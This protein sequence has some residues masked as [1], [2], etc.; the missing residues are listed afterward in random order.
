[1]P[2]ASSRQW[3]GESIPAI[4][5]LCGICTVNLKSNIRRQSPSLL[6]LKPD[7]RTAKFFARIGYRALGDDGLLR[8]IMRELEEEGFLLLHKP[9]RRRE[10]AEMVRRALAG[11]D[12]L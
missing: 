3:F 8:A 9:Y 12:P 11:P 5:S 4:R 2:G 7:W 1:M 6:S 10:L